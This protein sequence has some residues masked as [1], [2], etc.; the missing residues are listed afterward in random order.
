MKTCEE[1]FEKNPPPTSHDGPQPESEARGKQ[2]LH[3]GARAVSVLRKDQV[4]RDRGSPL[5]FHAMFPLR[6]G[7]N[8]N[9]LPQRLLSQD[10]PVTPAEREAAGGSQTQRADTRGGKKVRLINEKSLKKVKQKRVEKSPDQ[11]KHR[12]VGLWIVWM[13]LHL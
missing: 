10:T 9:A 13:H 2:P 7:F 12:L 11:T 5:F 8:I 6:Q 1:P 3:L 4:H